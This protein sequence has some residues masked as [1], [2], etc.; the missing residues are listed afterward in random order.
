MKTLFYTLASII[1]LPL[2]ILTIWFMLALGRFVYL[3]YELR[4]TQAPAGW[5]QTPPPEEMDEA[6]K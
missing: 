4:Q 3:N 5:N 2:A 6:V 1:L